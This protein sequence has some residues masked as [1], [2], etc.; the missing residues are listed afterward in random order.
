[1]SWVWRLRNIGE[2]P[3]RHV[4]VEAALSSLSGWSLAGSYRPET[5][6]QGQFWPVL[7]RLALKGLRSAKTGL[8]SGPMALDY[9]TLRPARFG[10]KQQAA[11]LQ[12]L[13]PC[14][15]GEIG[16]LTRLRSVT[17]SDKQ[18]HFHSPSN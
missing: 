5:G 1:V 6:P 8:G 11:C 4:E 16:R 12:M 10:S 3:Q 15:S 18:S 2:V 17:A 9:A 13:D 7:L 14:E